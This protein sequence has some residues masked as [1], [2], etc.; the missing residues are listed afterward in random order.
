MYFM[1]Y[2]GEN[3][4]PKYISPSKINTFNGCPYRYWSHY[5]AKRPQIRVPD[6]AAL[7]GSAVH[8]IVVMYYDKISNKP[9]KK[10]MLESFFQLSKK[11]GLKITPQR[12][13][14]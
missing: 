6:E 9:D 4:L 12:T 5:I 14:I 10:E 13:A 2:R 1:W 8:N 3:V 11:H 7:F